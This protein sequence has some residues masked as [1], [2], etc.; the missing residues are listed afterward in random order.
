[1]THFYTAG[2]RRIIY[3]WVMDDC[4]D[5]ITYIIKIIHTIIF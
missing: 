3:D 5:D 1:M 4:H 2:I